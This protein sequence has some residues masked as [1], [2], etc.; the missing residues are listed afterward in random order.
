MKPI[1]VR[2]CP[3]CGVKPRLVKVVMKRGRWRWFGQCGV[4]YK[5]GKGFSTPYEAMKS[6][7]EVLDV[8]KG[9]KE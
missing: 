7:E 1:E 2:V 4:C 8:E 5:S 6:W 3:R 9:G